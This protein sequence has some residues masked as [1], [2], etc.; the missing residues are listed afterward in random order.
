V[1]LIA[2]P[3]V[4]YTEVGIA[5][6]IAGTGTSFCFP[7]VANAIMGSVPPSE[8][9]IAAGTNS[10]VREL[11][12]VFGVSVLASVF[13]GHDVFASPDA[14]VAG[15]TDALWVAVGFSVIGVLAALF[16][17]ARSAAPR[18]AVAPALGA[19]PAPERP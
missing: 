16:T 15:F 6:L 17:A 10:T 4:S 18:E 14:F 9:G 7:T 1:A 12:G 19:A 3:T 2:S 8:A 11:G 13:A 5:L